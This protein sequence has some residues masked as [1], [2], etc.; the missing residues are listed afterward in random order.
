MPSQL[1]NNKNQKAKYSKDKILVPKRKSLNGI[2]K[3]KQMKS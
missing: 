2:K 1:Q 3:M